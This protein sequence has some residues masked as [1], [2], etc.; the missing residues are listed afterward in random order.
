MRSTFAACFLIM[1]LL[2]CNSTL[3]QL[4]KSIEIKNENVTV[5]L[6]NFRWMTTQDTTSNNGVS[7]SVD[8]KPLESSK[9]YPPS[10]N[11]YLYFDY[12]KRI[13]PTAV[14]DGVA[15]ISIGLRAGGIVYRPFELKE[16]Q[17]VGKIGLV[18]RRDDG[19][20]PRIEGDFDFP[21]VMYGRRTSGSPLKGVES[22][23]KLKLRIAIDAA[24]GKSPES[25]IIDFYVGTWSVELSQTLPKG[26]PDEFIPTK[27]FVRT[28]NNLPILGG[29]F[30]ETVVRERMT[31][32][33]DLESRFMIGY[34]DKK[35]QFLSW[36]FC[37]EGSAIER[38][39]TWNSSSKTMTWRATSGNLTE[40]EIVHRIV[41]AN[42]YEHLLT[43]SG[44]DDTVH[45][46]FRYSRVLNSESISQSSKQVPLERSTHDW[47]SIDGKQI[48]AKFNKV[49][50]ESVLLEM[51]GN[52]Y[53]I[54][55]SKLSPESIELAKSLQKK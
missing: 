53:T 48:N 11:A 13:E 41:D 42:T 20:S 6:S 24:T 40:L 2:L 37:S 5:D 19:P 17:G 22:T 12:K 33:K 55:F 25:K 26:N 21:I 39:G 7:Q 43:P 23:E 31:N 32:G 8:P 15:A 35:Q 45:T 28:R 3:G 46:R 29:K 9:L 50:G 44:S 10:T 38:I 14:P 52:T 18:F 27:G 1:P 49:D 51:N 16:S 34:D 4:P 54:P 47:S 36:T 30:V